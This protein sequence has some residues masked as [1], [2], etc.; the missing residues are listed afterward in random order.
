MLSL[1]YS[2][3]YVTS[4][5]YNTKRAYY[6]EI[7]LLCISLFTLDLKNILPKPNSDGIIFTHR[8]YIIP[9]QCLAD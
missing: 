8:C 7:E 4:Y 2:H 9:R 5:N 6:A 3:N 1:N